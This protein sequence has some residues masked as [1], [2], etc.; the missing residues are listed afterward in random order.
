MDAFMDAELRADFLVEAGELVK[1]LGEPREAAP[2]DAGLLNEARSSA[3][4]L[5]AAQMD[6][7]L[8]ALDDL[9][10]TW[11]ARAQEQPLTMSPHDFL[12]HSTPPIS[13]P[14]A[15]PLADVQTSIVDTSAP[16]APPRT[17]A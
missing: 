6:A 17:S 7:L 15:A 4:A 5:D 16:L 8:E 3:F 12:A 2:R 10:D 14:T 13:A 9:Q 11:I 1:R